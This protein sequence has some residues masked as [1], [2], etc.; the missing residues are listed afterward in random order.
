MDVLPPCVVEIEDGLLLGLEV[1]TRD[2]LAG[3][4][5]GDLGTAPV[6]ACDRARVEVEAPRRAATRVVLAWSKRL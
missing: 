2:D 6:D 3:S 1:V 4:D 5:R